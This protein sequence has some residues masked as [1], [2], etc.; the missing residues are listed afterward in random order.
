MEIYS[1]MIRYEEGQNDKTKRSRLKQED[2]QRDLLADY[3]EERKK[4]RQKGDKKT[5]KDKK[6]IEELDKEIEALNE[7]MRQH[8]LMENDPSEEEDLEG[9]SFQDK[10]LQTEIHTACGALSKVMDIIDTP[11]FN[12]KPKLWQKFKERNA[13]YL[14]KLETIHGNVR[15]MQLVAEMKQTAKKTKSIDSLEARLRAI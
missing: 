9:L 13:E 5:D 2:K 14:A 11:L 6:R 7:Y 10:F 4:L 15:T 3:C 8:N 1:F 12:T